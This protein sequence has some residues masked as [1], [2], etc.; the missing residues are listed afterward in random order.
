MRPS[1]SISRRRFLRSSL[2]LGAGL[3][4][5]ALLAACTPAP[6]PPSK[7]AD[8]PKPAEAAKPTAAPAKPAEVAKPAEAPKPTAAPAAQA[9]PAKTQ[10]EKT[11]VFAQEA[12]PPGMDP[13]RGQ[14]LIQGKRVSH[15]LYDRPVN[16]DKEMQTV[17]GAATEWRS[18][19]DRTWQ[20]KIR[21]GVKFHDGSALDA[22]AVKLTIETAVNPDSKN[23]YAV[24]AGSIAGA[25]VVDPLTLNVQTRDPFP[26][27]P[28]G[29]SLTTEVVP[30]TAHGGW[31]A[32]IQKPVGTG[33]FKFVEFRPNDRVVLEANP[34]YW[35]GRPQVDR[36]IIRYIPDAATRAAA[37]KA[38]EVHLASGL[39]ID[40]A[41]DIEASGHK[42]LG[43]LLTRGLTIDFNEQQKD[44]PINKDKRVRQ[45]LN[46]A[47]DKETINK[48]FLLGY[49]AV[50]DAQVPQKGTFG[51]NPNL[52]PYPY[53]PDRAKALLAEAGFPNGFEMEL[54][55]QPAFGHQDIAT[56]AAAQ[57][58]KVG[59]RVKVTVLE[60]GV[61]ANQKQE[62]KLG[63]A[64]TSTWAALGDASQN[65]VWFT[66]ASTIGK[67]HLNPEWDELILGASKTLDMKKR[68]EMFHKVTELMREDPPCIWTVRMPEIW[69]VAKNVQNE[70]I[71]SVGFA[72][73]NN[74]DLS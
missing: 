4:G 38:G 58:G 37:V 14:Q 32:F 46:Y 26:L 65:L 23:T 9:A 10:A 50:M 52:K 59:V 3:G 55:S 71:N 48:E 1:P 63:P 41:K 5:T 39:P 70:E 61:F 35:G 67:Y 49:G 13:L 68:E 28:M 22:E 2:L 60:A 18:L 69:G 19:D 62:T 56:I 17:P 7:P 31:D 72:Y 30:K 20:F 11:L 25:E 42:A 73:F 27:V 15:A 6:A 16:M 64:F 33:P 34:D 45:A 29:L 53:D 54:F 12:F 21:P 36:L 66:S 43:I 8:A 24:Y 47:L 40:A 51:Y 57:L 74:T 44:H